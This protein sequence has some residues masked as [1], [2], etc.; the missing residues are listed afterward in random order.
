MKD[1][2]L[3]WKERMMN[4]IWS[5]FR[6]GKLIKRW[7]EKEKTFPFRIHFFPPFFDPNPTAISQPTLLSTQLSH[8]LEVQPWNFSLPKQFFCFHTLFV[9]YISLECKYMSYHFMGYYKFSVFTTTTP[10]KQHRKFL[11]EMLFLLVI[12]TEDI[13]MFLFVL[14]FT[15]V[16]GGH[17]EGRGERGG[18]PMWIM[19]R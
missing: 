17:G 16:D 8:I 18:R 10:R 12:L 3:S 4:F 7:Y 13:C 5:Y 15:R 9:V 19:E 1:F 6:N 14:S 2:T 11:L